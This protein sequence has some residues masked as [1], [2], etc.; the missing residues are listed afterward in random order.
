MIIAKMHI[1]GVKISI[2]GPVIYRLGKGGGGLQDFGDHLIFRRTKRG[3]SR[4]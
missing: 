2:K 1:K 3:I 4:N